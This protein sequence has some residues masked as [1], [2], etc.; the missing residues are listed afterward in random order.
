MKKVINEYINDIHYLKVDCSDEKPSVIVDKKNKLSI[1]FN[2]YTLTKDKTVRDALIDF[3]TKG[4][5]DFSIVNLALLFT[6]IKSRHLT[7]YYSTIRIIFEALITDIRLEAII[8]HNRENTY[9]VLYAFMDS[10]L[11]VVNDIVDKTGLSINIVRKELNFLTK[12][13]AYSDPVIEKISAKEAGYSDMKNRY[14]LSPIGEN[15]VDILYSA[16]RAQ[17]NYC[18]WIDMMGKVCNINAN[19]LDHDAD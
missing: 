6:K 7:E 3:I 12:Y 13:D 11:L 8:N 1:L 9:K 16:G 15:V 2:Y 5:T 14:R 17:T 18:K 10:D 19:I 4:D